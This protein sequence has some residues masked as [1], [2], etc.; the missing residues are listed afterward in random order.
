[1]K[2]LGIRITIV[3][4]ILSLLS[5]RKTTSAQLGRDVVQ[6]F[7]AVGERASSKLGY[8]VA[9]L[10]DQNGDGFDD[11]LVSAPGDRKAFIY[12][13]GNPM[14]TIPDVIFHE[15]KKG[16]GAKLCNLGD[17]NGDTFN[18][19]LI[20][21][22]ENVQ[23]Y[24]G[25]QKLDTLADLILPDMT[26]VGAAGDVNGDGYSD[27]LGADVNWQS[28][29]GKVYLFLGGIEPDSLADWSVT[30]DSA[31]YHLGDGLV[32]NGDI[33]GDDYDDIAIIGWRLI[34]GEAYP[35]LKM[36]YGGAEMDSV[37]AFIIDSYDQPIDLGI[38]AA[39]INVNGDS[40]SDLCIDCLRD[41][42]ALL[43]WG[44]ILPDITPDIELKGNSLSGEKWEIAEA[45]DIN[46]DGY[47][48]I[49][50]GNW[51]GWNNTGEVLVFLGGPYMDGEYDIG[52]TGYMH[53]YEGAGLSVGSA[54]DVN[55]DG[56]DDILFGAWAEYGDNKQ[57]RVM[58]FSGDTTL[59]MVASQ[60]ANSNKPHCYFLRQNYPNPFNSST[61]I[62]YEVSVDNPIQIVLKIFNIL[63]EYVT[64][65]VNKPHAAGRYQTI[66][67]GCDSTGISVGSGI[68][69][70]H[71]Q[72]RNQ[73][74][75]IKM[76]LLR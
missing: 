36:F 61:I 48:D 20:K 73:R 65:L 62:E 40:Y 22:S 16:F 29:R 70:G 43:F 35:Y 27:I 54:G 46:N 71:L 60:S 37:P 10:G 57:G 59:T 55:G 24:W 12:F 34:M 47:P 45:G 33:N 64:T 39:F 53:S 38:R 49:I 13:G 1:M 67:N 41:T 6:L 8:Q 3:F 72:I 26:H 25:G 11:I 31:R 30:G 21:S 17:V 2:I 44:P 52:F 58:I 32:G 7:E 76:L 51:D 56:V 63:G 75:I 74:Q 66:W 18:D 19:F 4:V 69:F 15:S 9:G 23:V 5:L 14:D 50:I 42:A 68:Y 28:G